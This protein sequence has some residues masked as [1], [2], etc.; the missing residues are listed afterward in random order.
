MRLLCSLFLLF[1]LHGI[2]SAQQPA[3]TLSSQMHEIEVKSYRIRSHLSGRAFEAVKW[4][5]SMMEQMPQIL[6]NADPMHYLQLLPSVQTN[7]ELD[8][9]IHVHGCSSSQSIMQI[10]DAPVYN[11]A[12]MMG[13]FSTFNAS[14]YSSLLY[15]SYNEVNTPN[16]LGGSIQMQ[17]RMLQQDTISGNLSLGLISSQGTLHLPLGKNQ[18]LS[19][20][21]RQTYINLLYGSYLK[22]DDS[23][24]SYGFGDF[25]LTYSVQ[26]PRHSLSIDAFYSNDGG[27]VGENNIDMEVDMRWQNYVVAAQLDSKPMRLSDTVHQSLYFSG[28]NNRAK[29][30]MVGILG[31][32]PSNI[33]TLGYHLEAKRNASTQHLPLNLSWG[34]DLMQHSILP[35][36]PNFKGNYQLDMQPIATQ[37]SVQA[38]LFLQG[39]TLLRKNLGL[40][41]GLRLNAYALLNDSTATFFHPDPFVSLTYNHPTAGEFQLRLNSQHQYIHQ[42]GFSSMGLPTEFRFSS[43]RLYKPQNSFSLS[44][45]YDREFF[46]RRYRFKAE[47]YGMKME[48]QVDYHG[49]FLSFLT[50]GYK[51]QSSIISGKGYNYG[52]NLQIIKQTGRLTGWVSY[53]YGRSKRHFTEFSEK[54]WYPSNYERPHEVNAVATYRFNEHWSCGSTFAFASGTPFTAIKYIYMMSNVLVSQYGEHNANRLRPYLRLDLSV[55]YEFCKRLRQGINLSLYNATARHNDIYC[56][57]KIY[58]GNY[59][60]H[61]ISFMIP[62]LPSISYFIKL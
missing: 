2:I 22:M 41:A 28:Y 42:A 53:A 51:M 33:N 15:R 34:T 45:G 49:D 30:N 32:L 35:Q 56:R 47:L 6:S 1:L 26:L 4:D 44:L 14:H 31:S 17:S 29:I 23:D 9:G 61:P 19:V 37:R 7:N 36:A 25:N 12:H 39:S 58:K 54:H 11:P 55:N 38:A 62:I 60:Y 21:A 3:D 18:S 48:H 24:Y 57:L 20:S 50:S 43:S 52:L 46:G 16:V 40:K 13:F 5:M 27:K 59:S 8:A 10:G